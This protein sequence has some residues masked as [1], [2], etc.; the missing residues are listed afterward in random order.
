MEKG[1]E[2]E[3]EAE[4]GGGEEFISESKQGMNVFTTTVM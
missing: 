1:G 3:T 2:T 4:R